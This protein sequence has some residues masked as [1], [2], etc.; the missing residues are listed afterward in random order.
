MTTTEINKMKK[1]LLESVEKT[2]EK[3]AVIREKRMKLQQINEM[4]K[5][6]KE[7]DEYWSKTVS[8]S[9]L[10]DYQSGHVKTVFID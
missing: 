2:R 6:K 4:A 3:I 9:V 7:L 10:D 5:T 8:A 1:E